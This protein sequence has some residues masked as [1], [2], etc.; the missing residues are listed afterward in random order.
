MDATIENYRL[1]R[2]SKGT[3]NFQTALQIDKSKCLA[4]KR[5]ALLVKNHSN[6][7]LI[8]IRMGVIL[9]EPFLTKCITTISLR[10]YPGRPGP[11][12]KK[13]SGLE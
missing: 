1:N 12:Q 6:N 9:A 2:T 5:R 7:H 4:T 11:R 3:K 10:W 8:K 13:G